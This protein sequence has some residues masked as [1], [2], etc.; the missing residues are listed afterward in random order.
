MA[1]TK[2]TETTEVKKE[3]AKV[4]E[5]KKEAVKAPETK[6]EAVKAPE[7]KKA[8]AKKETVKKTAEKKPAAKKAAAPKAAAVKVVL[9]F[10]GRQVSADDI[11]AA[12]M[13]KAGKAKTVE[14]YVKPEDGAAYYVADGETGKVEF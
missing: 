5:T 3:T 12:V 7:T 10:Q 8:P 14:V 2:K 1:T 13:A 6:K 11:L 4:A 9:E